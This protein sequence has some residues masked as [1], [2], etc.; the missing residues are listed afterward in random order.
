MPGRPLQEIQILNND[1]EQQV[2]DDEAESYAEHA[3]LDAVDL[4]ETVNLI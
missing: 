4:V 3:D 1:Q 2:E